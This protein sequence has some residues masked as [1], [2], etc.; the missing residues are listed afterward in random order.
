MFEQG[1]QGAYQQ[2]MYAPQPEMM[3]RQ[4]FQPMQ[5]QPQYQP[6]RPPQNG[7]VWVQGEA[8]A[9]SYLIAAGNTVPLWDSENQTIYI[10][11]V[12]A[13]GVP[14]MRILDYKER[15]QSRSAAAQ[16]FKNPGDEYVTRKEFEELAAKISA[17]TVKPV[18]KT[19]KEA[20]AN[21]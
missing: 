15:A 21:G 3:M 2:P 18:R 10:K 16:V 13:S 11:T 9:K 14:S 6:Q 20:D 4:Q 7:M 12:D 1:Y 17:L 19:V 5:S 8:G